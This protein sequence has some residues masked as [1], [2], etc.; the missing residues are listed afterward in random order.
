MK[1]N[2]KLILISFLLF[3]CHSVQHQVKEATYT[4]YKIS[5]EK[6]P[7]SDSATEALIAP[8]RKVLSKEMN[9][10]VTYAE[11]EFQKGKPEGSLGNLICD[12]LLAY[13]KGMGKDADVC[14]FNNGGIRIP[15]L[16]IGEVTVQTLF[17]LMPFENELTLLKVSGS[18]FEKMAAA[19]AYEGGIP[20]SG[21][22]MKIH[23]GQALNIQIAGKAFDPT[24]SYWVVTSDYLANGGDQSDALKLPEERIDLQIKIRDVL[25]KS[26]RDKYTNGQNIIAVKDGR[27]S[28]E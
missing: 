23:N 25:I 13:V 28:E 26:L 21:M 19:I 10:V 17:E 24:K 14:I 9:Q 7:E 18:N 3:S 11:D 27:I 20:V 8:Y 1:S 15:N 5:L 6:T 22:R 12:E 4:P 16:Y 2:S